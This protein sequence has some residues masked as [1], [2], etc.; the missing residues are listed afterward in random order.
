MKQ[1]RSSFTIYAILTTLTLLSWAL[2][3][4]YTRLVKIDLTVMPQ[5][6]LSPV[7]PNLDTS[8]LDLLEDKKFATD[9]EISSF[10]PSS[11]SNSQI[12]STE[13]GQEASPDGVNPSA[14]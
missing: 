9:S 8:V 12:E 5:S 6:V 4:A 1:K 3:G 11:S 7:N 10:E 2:Y 14:Q 13:S